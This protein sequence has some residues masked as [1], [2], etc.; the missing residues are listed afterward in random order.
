MVGTRSAAS[1][2]VGTKT[3]HFYFLC[4]LLFVGCTGDISIEGE[5]GGGRAN[6]ADPTQPE[7]APETY[8]LDNDGVPDVFWAAPA[9]MRRLT[10]E[11]YTNSVRDIF[12]DVRVPSDLEADTSLNGFVSIGN[13]RTTISPVGV[14]KYESAAYDIA[15]QVVSTPALSQ[16]LF[17]CTP[18][19]PQD[20]ACAEQTLRTLGR[21]VFRRPLSESELARYQQVALMASDAVGDFYEGFGYAIAGLLQS[22]KFLFRAELGEAS[23]TQR[24][25]TDFEMA[26]RVSFLLWNTTPDDAL[27]D[28]AA[29]G[30]LTRDDG[31]REHVTRL[32]QS[33]R[34]ADAIESFFSELLGVQVNYEK[35]ANIFPQASPT[36][37]ASAREG[38]LQTV[39]Y[40]F[41]EQNTAY[42]ELFTTEVTYV[43]DELA[44]LYGI[45]R[46]SATFER[47]TLPNDEMRSGLLGQAAFL[48]LNAHSTSSSP[49]LRGR[50]VRQNLLCQGIPAPPPNVG[51]LPEP[52]PDLPTMRERL[53]VHREN[54]T[55]A[56]CHALTDPVG[57]GL[58]NFDGIGAFR[59]FENGAQ[60]DASGDLDGLAFDDARGVG[61]AVSQHPELVGCLV[62]NVYRFATGHLETEGEE[63]VVRRLLDAL[64]DG[65]FMKELLIEVTLS[66]GFRKVGVGI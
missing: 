9:S 14:E 6:G 1:E 25:Y 54:D 18:S 37:S 15:A 16:A 40:L 20:A 10:V 2:G 66:E 26:S 61:E 24:T 30:E 43:N 49:T 28:A 17:S 63:V 31:L 64:A 59:E 50:F 57:L 42:P 22:P 65:A 58:E 55:C 19:G 44:S 39:R 62:R 38:V 11:Q 8:D 35:D 36:F 52:S 32:V 23:T 27:L 5:S 53:S 60:I 41:A 48:A 46:G 34:A 47:V 12:G 21:R 29:G 51:E 3:K 13:S 4:P 7:K 56:S 45:G 33:P